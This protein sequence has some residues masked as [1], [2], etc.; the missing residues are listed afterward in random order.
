MVGGMLKIMSHSMAHDRAQHKH[1]C[2]QQQTDT[3]SKEKAVTAFHCGPSAR[4]HVSKV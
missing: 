4:A 3:G 2:Q 1:H